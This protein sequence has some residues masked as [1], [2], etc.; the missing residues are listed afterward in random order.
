[1]LG[2]IDKHWSIASAS[3]NIESFFDDSGEIGDVFDKE[4]VLGAGT[5]DS[6]SID[7][8]KGICANLRHRDLSAYNYQRDRIHICCGDSGYGVG[9]AR[10]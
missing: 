4:V 10:T 8:L 9:K 3:S 6:H 7:F 5:R 2:E 1:M